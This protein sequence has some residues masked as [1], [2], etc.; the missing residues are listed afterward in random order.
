MTEVYLTWNMA[1]IGWKNKSK[2]WT[3]NSNKKP[4]KLKKFNN[5]IEC[6]LKT[7]KDDYLTPKWFGKNNLETPSA[8]KMYKFKL[9]KTLTN[10]KSKNIK[11]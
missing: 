4:N 11:N 7:Y 9:S 6:K 3:I 2:I 10:K 1:M 5:E 8:G